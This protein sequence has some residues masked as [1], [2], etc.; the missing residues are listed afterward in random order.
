MRRCEARLILQPPTAGVHFAVCKVAIS[1][2]R[3]V[4]RPDRFP[5]QPRLIVAGAWPHDL[6]D[7]NKSDGS[8]PGR[9]FVTAERDGYFLLPPANRKVH[10][11]R[12]GSFPER[13][14]PVT[15]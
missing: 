9:A 7:E 14:K 12:R 10:S 8:S 2:R 6:F 5:L 3:D 11:N 15:F 4:A 1:L 13:A